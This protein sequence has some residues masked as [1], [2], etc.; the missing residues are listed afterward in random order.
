MLSREDIRLL[1]TAQIAVFFILGT[2]PLLF[3]GV[4]PVVSGAYTLFIFIILGGWLLLNTSFF[5]YQVLCSAGIILF[6][7][8]IIVI[9][10]STVPVPITWLQTL[11]PARFASIQPANNLGGI[12]IQ[13]ASLSHNPDAGIL[14]FTFLIAL[15]IYSL[16]LNILLK[17]DRVFLK[18]ILYICSA[19]GIFEAMYGLVQAANPHIGVLWLNDIRQFQGMARGTIIYKNQ[20]A[21]LLN[22]IWPLTFGAALLCF[23]GT[24]PH[25]KSSHSTVSALSAL[26]RPSHRR[27]KKRPA[28]SPT[29]HR[30]QGYILLFFTSILML[31]NLFS[32]SRGGTLSMIFIVFLLVLVIPISYRIKSF[33][34]ISLLL[35]I[36]LY[37]SLI[38]FNNIFERFMLIQ[39]SSDVRLNIWLS[40]LPMLRDYIFSGSGIDSYITLSAVYLKHFPENILFDHAHNDYLEFAI[41]LGLP[42]ALFFFTAFIIIFLRTIKK[43]WPYTK[44]RFTALPSSVI[45]A[46]V[47]APALAGFLVHGTVDFGWRLPA[48]LFYATT[49]IVLLRHGAQIT[50]RQRLADDKSQ[51]FRTAA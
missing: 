19:V 13:Y 45:I 29:K 41:E 47:S 39:E 42:L 43:I 14:T 27:K 25:R 3:G 8:L 6:C 4:H 23:K 36:A 17:N 11:S 28:H 18:K 26:P 10:L 21:A 33:F 32:Q 24:T 31:A 30:L 46:L 16:V 51:L 22:M 9:I 48:N 34:S 40:S 37:G 38:G 12:N 35:F 5:H 49:L 15:V 2:I 20:Y 7:L 44:T 1:K 50:E